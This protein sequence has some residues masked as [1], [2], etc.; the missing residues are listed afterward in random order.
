MRWLNYTINRRHN[1]TETSQKWKQKRWYVFTLAG[2]NLSKYQRICIF[3]KYY[4]T[5]RFTEI[6]HL[7]TLQFPLTPCPS[8]S[9]IWY[10]VKTYEKHVP[11]LIGMGKKPEGNGP[12]AVTKTSMP[13]TMRWSNR[14]GLRA[15]WMDWGL[16]SRHSTGLFALTLNRTHIEYNDST[17]WN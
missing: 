10:N 2:E 9:T 15:E 7:F 14:W 12:I 3:K 17:N 13:Y 6:R 1:K 11:A 4:E 5:K 16:V 8:K